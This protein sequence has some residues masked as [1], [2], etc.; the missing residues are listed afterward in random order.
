MKRDLR[1][2]L[3]VTAVDAAARGVLS[4]VLSLVLLGRDVSL[5]QLPLALAVFS[6]VAVALEVP[7]GMLADRIGRKRTFVAAQAVYA[8]AMLLLLFG[9]GMAMACA[10]LAVNGVARALA[11]GSLDALV[12]D[13]CLLEQGE[14]GLAGITARQGACKS[15]GLAVGALLGGVLNG[16]GGIEAALLCAVALTVLALLGAAACTR[17]TGGRPAERPGLRSQLRAVAEACRE[18]RRLPVLLASTALCGVLMMLVET[19]WQPRFTALLPADS[20][21]WLLG[22]LG[23]GYFAAS[24]FGSL[25]AE[26][27]VKRL[28]ANRIFLLG[29]ALSAVCLLALSAVRTPAGFSA[30][31]LMLYLLMGAADTAQGIA[32]H[33]ATPSA[34][35]ATVL[36]GQGLT[37]QLGALSASGA[38]GLT[39]GRLSIPALWQLGA[40]LFLLGIAAVAL[41]LKK[42]AR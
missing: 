42:A 2:G 19:Y 37:L 41:L 7:S 28:G 11:S 15:A 5:A 8:L 16:F 1:A 24:I 29:Y 25:A 26:R 20:L 9:R 17:E 34:V 3:A 33:R 10:A 21:L 30:L 23:F 4:P 32:I 22:L 31:Y 14:A 36:S 6:G 27:A 39:A 12:V 18:S 40:V 13:A 38:A 35:R